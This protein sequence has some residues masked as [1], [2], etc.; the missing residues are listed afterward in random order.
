MVRAGVSENVAMKISVQETPSVF[1]RRDITNESD[2]A[3]AAKKLESAEIS[4]KLATENASASQQPAT[5]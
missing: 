1:D 3:D 2:L 4:R 5:D